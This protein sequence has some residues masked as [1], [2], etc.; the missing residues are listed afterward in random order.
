MGYGDYQCMD[1]NGIREDGRKADE[2]R[3]VE[4]ECGVVPVADGR[5]YIKWGKNEAIAAVY[6]PMEAHPRKIQRQDRA[7]LDVRYN[8]APFSTSDRIRPG[9]NRRSREISKV[10][11]DALESVV[12]LELYPRSKIR[13][14]IEIICAEAGTR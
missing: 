6:G 12:D 10:T 8:M 1:E 9:F 2:M 7:I 14:E 3:P 5:A 4:I 13:V 11:R